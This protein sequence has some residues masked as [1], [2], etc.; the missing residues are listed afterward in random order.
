MLFVTVYYLSLYSK[1]KKKIFEIW[2]TI[3]YFLLRVH[4]MNVKGSIGEKHFNNIK[5]GVLVNNLY[6]IEAKETHS[7]FY[8]KSEAL[9]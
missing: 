9:N 7:N 3:S 8:V 6:P 4:S 5:K 2:K 1:T